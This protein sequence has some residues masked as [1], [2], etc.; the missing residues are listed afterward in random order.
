MNIQDVSNSLWAFSKIGAPSRTPAVIKQLIEAAGQ[1]LPS[2]GHPEL[3]QLSYAALRFTTAASSSTVTAPAAIGAGPG[4]LGGNDMVGVNDSLA[5]RHRVSSLVPGIIRAAEP[6]LPSMSY[7]S[8]S[9]ILVSLAGI[10]PPHTPEAASP[11]DDVGLVN[12]S[13]STLIRNDS[14]QPAADIATRDGLNGA[15]GVNGADGQ[16]D[17]KSKDL[18]TGSLLLPPGWIRLAAARTAKAAA[19]RSHLRLPPRQRAAMAERVLLALERLG[20][21]APGEAGRQAWASELEAHVQPGRDPSISL[22]SNEGP[23]NG[24]AAAKYNGVAL[25][26]AMWQNLSAAAL[27]AVA[28]IEWRGGI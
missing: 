3:A 14:Q 25:R 9:V 28:Y 8:L 7:M 21:I 26:E 12:K 23:S 4:G 1:L 24:A 10:L 27:G 22:N 19:S 13:S 20:Y 16:E 6:L 17:A 15:D 11:D 5:Y 18:T 2:A